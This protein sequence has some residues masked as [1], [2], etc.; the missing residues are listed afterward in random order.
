[1]ILN[2]LN[3]IG[4]DDVD[5][6][7]DGILNDYKKKLKD[8]KKDINLTGK[9]IQVA[10]VEQASLLAYYD[11][12]KVNLK[13]LVEHYE[14][15]V[16]QIRSDTLRMIYTSAKYDYSSTERERIIDGDPK[17]IKYKGIYN[18]VVEMYTLAASITDQFKGRAYTIHNQIEILK[19][20]LQ[21]V[22]LYVD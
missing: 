9:N 3:E 21:D 12:V 22:T 19:A 15:R 1:M 2:D 10:N 7:I 4:Q 6:V 14:M 20:G 17:Y 18:R 5:E 8:W 16:K 11:E 13:S